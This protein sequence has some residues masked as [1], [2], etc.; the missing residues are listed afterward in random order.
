MA[1]S[2]RV[3][4][5]PATDLKR[6]ICSLCEEAGFQIGKSQIVMKREEQLQKSFRVILTNVHEADWNPT[7]PDAYVGSQWDEHK[8]NQINV[9]AFIGC[10]GSFDGIIELRCLATDVVGDIFSPT[11]RS[12]KIP[13]DDLPQ[14]L[15]E[16]ARQ[17]RAIITGRKQGE[18]GPWQFG[19]MRWEYWKM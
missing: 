12:C 6:R 16:I 5:E 14:W 9:M 1:F 19:E 15:P 2:K 10:D 8:T 3:G 18:K 7:V 13:I 11:L 4:M 17:M